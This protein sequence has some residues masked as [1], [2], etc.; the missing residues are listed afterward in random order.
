MGFL[1]SIFG[2]EYKLMNFE[3]KGRFFSFKVKIL[4]DFSSTKIY[5]TDNGGKFLI[6]Y[7]FYN[8]NKDFIST[9]FDG[10][11]QHETLISGQRLAKEFAIKFGVDY[12]NKYCKTYGGTPPTVAHLYP[13]KRSVGQDDDRYYELVILSAH[14]AISCNV[15]GEKLYFLTDGSYFFDGGLHISSDGELLE[16]SENLRFKYNPSSYEIDLLEIFNKNGI[17]LKHLK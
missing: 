4:F 13:S 16:N 14:K 1:D 11:F 17:H 8:S 6:V 5:E 7:N 10:L 2:D 15:E 9:N 3:R 12:F